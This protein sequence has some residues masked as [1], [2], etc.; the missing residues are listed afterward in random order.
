MK[1]ASDHC[2]QSSRAFELTI[3]PGR[4]NSSGHEVIRIQFRNLL[5]GRTKQ[6]H[7]AEDPRRPRTMFFDPDSRRKSWEE[8]VGCHA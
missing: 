5:L 8:T 6:L 3:I 1:S 4:L 7:P 2:F